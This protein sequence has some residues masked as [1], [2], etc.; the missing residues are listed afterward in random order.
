MWWMCH[1]SRPSRWTLQLPEYAHRRAGNASVRDVQR[2]DRQSEAVLS[3]RAFHSFSFVVGRFR[4]VTVRIMDIVW[5][6]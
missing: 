2:P 5:H 3:F 1:V 4:G 6:G